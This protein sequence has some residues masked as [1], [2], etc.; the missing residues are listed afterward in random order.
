LYGDYETHRT[1]ARGNETN[2]NIAGPMIGH[3]AYSE[4]YLARDLP[5]NNKTRVVKV[6]KET[7]LRRIRRELSILRELQRG[8]SIPALID[9]YKNHSSPKGVRICLVFRLLST[10]TLRQ[11]FK[12]I[13][14]LDIKWIMRDLLEALAYSHSR[15]IIHR[16]IKM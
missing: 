14:I 11:I 15:G 12:R 7:R 10:T 5:R 13:N 9:V 3:G 2:Y 8:P 16:D 6:L 1:Q 4:V